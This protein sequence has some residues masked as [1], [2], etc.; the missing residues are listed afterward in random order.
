MTSRTLLTWAHHEPVRGQIE[1][2][3][4]GR[5]AV[6]ALRDA[7]RAS[8]RRG[9]GSWSVWEAALRVEVW[10][11]WDGWAAPRPGRLGSWGAEGF[12][13]FLGAEVP[14][15][16]WEFK[17]R[18]E[19]AGGVRW[20][21][22]PLRPRAE[23]AGWNAN[24]LT[25]FRAVDGRS[26]LH[27]LTPVT[28]GIPRWAPHFARA[29]LFVDAPDLGWGRPVRG[30]LV[31]DA[32]G[33]VPWWGRGVWGRHAAALVPLPP[34]RWEFKWLLLDESGA[35]TWLAGDGPVRENEGWNKNGVVHVG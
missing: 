22:D 6:D 2:A 34:G 30:L 31:G 24:S 13:E 20:L 29:F 27:R 4:G 15:G 10:G 26:L 28:L 17:W 12:L 25:A 18:V 11:S 1:G 23:N 14:D 32:E 9:A 8:T 16:A 21:L 7:I 5:A 3:L 35:A 33:P 19:G